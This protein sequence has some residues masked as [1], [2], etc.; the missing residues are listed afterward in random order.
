MIRVLLIDEDPHAQ[1]TLNRLLPD[2]YQLSLCD[3]YEQADSAIKEEK[4]AII[5][6][7]INIDTA[8]S[9]NMLRTITS[10]MDAPPVIVH[11]TL[12]EPHY[13]V[14]AMRAGAHDY[15]VKP[16]SMS[17][18]LSACAAALQTWIS[19][20]P[21]NQDI[22]GYNLGGLV[23][24]GY[25]LN[26]QGPNR[27]RDWPAAR[28][29]GTS[30][31]T[32]RLRAALQRYAMTDVP[33]LLQGESGTGKDLAAQVVHAL[34]ARAN[35]PFI[36][37]NCGA[38]PADL[39]ETEMF[40]A[41]RGAYTGAVTRRGCFERANDGT[42]FLDE[43]GDMPLYMQV[44]L[45]RVL[46]EFK[47]TRIGGGKAIPLN[48]RVITATNHNIWAMARDGRFRQDLYY[49]IGVLVHTM[50]PLREQR[51]D[52]PALATHFLRRNGNKNF[53]IGA[54]EKLAAHDWPGNIRELRNCIE[55]AAALSN[56]LWLK[57]R[58]IQFYT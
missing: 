34:S 15:L 21:N 35:K 25:S 47:V 8:V 36:A 42:L 43:I 48:V 23:S 11:S 9:Y 54:I 26:G 4:P 44:K 45:L 33:L 17:R 3:F 19:S 16:C 18:L 10:R 1:H 57:E 27:Q 13:V 39:F 37:V 31:A 49:R 2:P 12:R 5:I 40:G 50:P 14:E 52:I 51:D 28:L 55:R 46:E 32:E 53:S 56:G 58:D 38:I 7:D 24:N 30:S 22:N 20:F 41:E 29:I 6:I